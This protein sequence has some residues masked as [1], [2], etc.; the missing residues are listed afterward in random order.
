MMIKM[1]A[2]TARVAPS[3]DCASV[4]VFLSTREGRG[5]GGGQGGVDLDS[6]GGDDDDGGTGGGCNGDGGTIGRSRDERRLPSNPQRSEG[7]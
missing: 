1:L 2:P 6:V 7:R 4:H 5:K 3:G